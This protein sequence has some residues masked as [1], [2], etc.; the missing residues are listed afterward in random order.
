MNL[1]C[2]SSSIYSDRLGRE[3]TLKGDEC[4]AGEPGVLA[5]IVLQKECFKVNF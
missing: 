1:D 3:D 2:Y 4:E 5:T